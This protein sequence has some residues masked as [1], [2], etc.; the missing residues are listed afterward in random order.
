[1]PCVQSDTLTTHDWP[2]CASLMLGPWRSAVP[3][4][5]NYALA[6]LAQWELSSARD[7]VAI[8]T[9]E[10][11]TNAVTASGTLT[12]GP[13]PVNLWLLADST[14]VLIM[15]G[16]A[17]AMPPGRRSPAEDEEGGR[18]LMLVEAFAARWSWSRYGRG[19]VVWALLDV[20][21]A[22]PK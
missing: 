16:D 6:C 11:V 10:L 8:C 14:Q 5:R 22:D 17:S 19:K 20:P 12:G 2:F 3:W 13:F 15:V 1:M 9:S 7:G 18:G 21:S 4:A